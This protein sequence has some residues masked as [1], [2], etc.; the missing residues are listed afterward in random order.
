MK[1]LVDAEE[2]LIAEELLM[3]KSCWC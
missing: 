2:L 1:V 3:L